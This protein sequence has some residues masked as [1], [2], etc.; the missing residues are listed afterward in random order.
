MDVDIYYTKSAGK[1]ADL[2][3]TQ[4]QKIQEK[5]KGLLKA[6]QEFIN[7]QK[8]QKTQETKKPK[9]IKQ[10]EKKW[11]EK[12]RWF[13][14]TN[15]FLAIAGR[16][17]KS[18]EH[19]VKKHME[20]EDLYFHADTH[21]AAHIILKKGQ[22]AKDVDQKEAACFAAIFS[23]A[24]KNNYYLQEV[25]SVLPDQVTKT[26]KSQESLGTGAF[27]IKGSRN[28]FRKNILE[29]YVSYDK[30][31]DNVVSGPKSAIINKYKFYV[32][33]KPGTT[34]KSD[35]CK[36]LCEKFKSKNIIVT[37]SQIDLFL[38][39]GGFEIIK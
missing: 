25:Y 8:I 20:N 15:N 2:K 16:D 12:Y 26:P 21:G 9:K 18:N 17:A 33:L 3:Y 14:T 24:W 37:E 30:D 34:K 1:N 29:I 36:L 4:K 39:S 31:L 32:G 28:Y 22:I 7:K 13:F 19:V 38:P 6:K 10:K 11:Y 35:V 27:V 5:I 23:S